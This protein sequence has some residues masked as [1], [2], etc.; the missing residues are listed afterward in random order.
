M[1]YNNQADTEILNIF[2]KKRT[3]KNN[4][5]RRTNFQQNGKTSCMWVETQIY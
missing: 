1:L 4:N 2:I 3:K 5:V